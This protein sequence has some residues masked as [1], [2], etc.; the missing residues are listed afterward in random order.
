[1][2]FFEAL[3]RRR[4]LPWVGAYLAGGFLGLEGI[5][6][7]VSYQ[8]VPQLLYR[9]ALVFYLFGIPGTIVVAWYHGEKGQ[10]K[11]ERTEIWLQVGLLAAAVSISVAVFRDYR[12]QEA[13]R[14]DVAAQIG[15]DPRGVAVLYFEDLDGDLGFA[16]DGLTEALIDR[17]EGVRALDVISRNGVEPFRGGDL[18]SDSIAR[19]LD[20]RNIVE[21]SV[22]SRGDEIRVTARL[23]DGLSGVDVDRT[24]FDVA[25]EELLGARDS[26]AA[27]ISESLRRR[28]GDEISVRETRGGTSDVEAWSLQRRAERLVRNAEDYEDNDEIDAALTTLTAADS[29]LLLAEIADPAWI[30][31]SVGRAEVR[32]IIAFLYAV[33]G[34]LETSA[35]EAREGLEF[36]ERALS[37]SPRAPEALEMRGTLNYWLWQLGA[38]GGH[39]DAERVLAS[40]REDLEAAVDADPT[41]ATAWSQLAHLYGNIGRL[42]EMIIAARRAYEEDAYLRTASR[43]LGQL[44]WGHFDQEQFNDAQSRCDI[45]RAR[46]PQDPRFVR[47]EMYMLLTPV[48][49][50]DPDSAWALQERLVELVPEG[51]RPYEE[52]LGYLLA[53]GVL[54]RAGLPDSADAVFRRGRAN[55]QFDPEMFLLGEE[56]KIRSA[57]GDLDDAME[58]AKQYVAANPGHTFQVG[59][60]MHWMWRPLRDHPEFR[61]L[62]ERR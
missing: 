1:M 40:A 52:R 5:D 2:R 14:I 24:S 18:T 44:F 46:F 39:D 41:L 12:A 50:P 17:L 6:Q 23:V 53:G 48:R 15:L 32:W 22:E 57:T 29:T 60:Q 31:P 38:A 19:I 11:L 25:P 8:I 55:Q 45:G 47:C 43:I 59:G 10:Q 4:I 51:Q 27:R 16:A 42:S 20:V 21:G 13:A 36:A 3:K 54:N 62:E 28:L 26:L 9:I 58:L 35:S 49:T 61:A 34:D 37:L 33:K 30:E 56:A 7:L